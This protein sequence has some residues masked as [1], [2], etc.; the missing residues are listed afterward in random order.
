[1]VVCKPIL[2]FS[3]SLS[4]A[5]Q[6]ISTQGASNKFIIDLLTFC[7][8]LKLCEIALLAAVIGGYI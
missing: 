5:E 2:V 7:Y 1:M 3:L 8:W 6:S 4:Q